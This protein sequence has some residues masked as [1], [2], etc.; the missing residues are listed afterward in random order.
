MA[1]V[2]FLRG[3]NVGGHKTFRPAALAK[4]MAELD[5]VSVGAAGTFVVRKPVSE[6]RLRAEILRR[7]PFEP[8][9]MICR[10]RDVLEL[11]RASPFPK[12]RSREELRR[13]VSVLGRRPRAAPAL[14]LERPAGG[15][16][17]VKLVAIAGPFVAS[18]WRRTGRAFLYPNEVVEK[19]L[20]VP[21]TTRSWSTIAAVC[22]LL[23]DR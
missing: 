11:E 5:V 9:V 2:V 19:E 14:P 21:A 16:W 17:Q 22:E 12:A 13:F 20:G 23:R 10:D 8:E 7:L 4:G 18:L 15:P 3:V 1:Q 6:P